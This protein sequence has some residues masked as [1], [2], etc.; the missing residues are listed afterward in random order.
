M[1]VA[2]N[3]KFCNIY[4]LKL[5]NRFGHML[6]T[7]C[8]ICLA[9]FWSKISIQWMFGVCQIHTFSK[10]SLILY[11]SIRSNSSFTACHNLNIYPYMSSFHIDEIVCSINFHLL[12][13]VIRC[14]LAHNLG[15]KK[16][17]KSLRNVNSCYLN[18]INPL[19][20]K[21]DEFGL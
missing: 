4:S 20:G 5:I 19:L 1:I 6:D 9:L 17:F 10:I 8:N 3:N 12:I 14:D 16:G 7:L 18:D 21:D 11:F 13:Y 2:W 15:W